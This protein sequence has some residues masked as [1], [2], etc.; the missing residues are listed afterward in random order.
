MDEFSDKVAW[1]I[2]QR[3]SFFARLL[4]ETKRA[5]VLLNS[6]LQARVR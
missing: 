1:I 5:R 3:A 6:F 4:L 2:V